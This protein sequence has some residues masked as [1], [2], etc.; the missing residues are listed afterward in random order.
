MHILFNPYVL[1]WVD[2]KFK[3]LY[4]NPYVREWIEVKLV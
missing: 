2:V 3:Y 4:V 1:K